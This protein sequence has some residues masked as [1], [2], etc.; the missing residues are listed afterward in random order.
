MTFRSNI[1][2]RKYLSYDDIRPKGDSHETE[3]DE[4]IDNDLFNSY[5]IDE[6]VLHAISMNISLIYHVKLIC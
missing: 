3:L 6:S 5:L 4:V 2:I 1:I